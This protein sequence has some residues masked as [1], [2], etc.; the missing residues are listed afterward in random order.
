MAGSG[1]GFRD[2][3]DNYSGWNGDRGRMSVRRVGLALAMLAALASDSWGKSRQP[4]FG[5]AAQAAPDPRG[6]EQ[7]PL[8]VKIMPSGAEPAAERQERDGREKAEADRLQA[9][10]I[11]RM[12][13]AMRWLV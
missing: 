6:T 3:A 11:Q 13:E 9:Q 1:S 4:A 8:A 7:M 2:D 10:E 12:A 5:Q